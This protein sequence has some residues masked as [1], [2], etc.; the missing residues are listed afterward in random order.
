[1]DT[2]EDRA[3]AGPW[4]TR[5]DAPPITQ[6]RRAQFWFALLLNF[7]WQLHQVRRGLLSSTNEATLQRGVRLHFDNYRSL[8]G[9]WEGMRA[10]Y[11]PEFVEGV[12]AQRSKTA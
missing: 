2:G 12:E 9:W 1:M 11:S 8:D 6:A 7:Q 10:Q 4:H 3:G 5:V